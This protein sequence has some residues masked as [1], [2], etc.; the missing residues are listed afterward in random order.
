MSKVA[1]IGDI[2]IG[3]NKN[4]PIFHKITLDYA[5]WLKKTLEEQSITNIWQLGDVFHDRVS[6]NLLTMDCAYKFFEKLQNFNI[7]IIIGNHDAF[8]LNNSSIHSLSFLK[9]WSNINVYDEVSLV[10]GVCFC[11]WGTSFD[12][13]PK[14]K[15]ILGHFEI[16]AFEMSKF[17]ICTKGIKGTELMSKCDILFTGHFHKPQERKYSNKPLIYTGSCFQLNW[18]ESEE[19][20]YV[21][22]FDTK[23][24]EFEKIENNISPK[25]IHIKSEKDIDKVNN[26]F[27]S[28]DI[29]D[30]EKEY[31]IV[32]T[33]E[34]LNPINIR[35]NYKEREKTKIDEDSISVDE[36]Q[37]V[38]IPGAI[39]EVS[40]GL[41][42]FT[43]DERNIIS[44]KASS[45]YKKHRKI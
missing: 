14:S 32:T 16:P 42:N 29:D 34:S 19:N 3:N 9:Q 37:L 5:D 22:I 30:Y 8:Y 4:N 38:D 33:Y 21:Y 35:T 36:L 7:S 45:L 39:E 23:T 1:I 13:I 20:K 18:G 44:E 40:N 41:E 10:N 15:I 12:D 31:E 24:L 43:D 6:I 28:I 17:K 2:H 26:N 25:F 11:P 27:I